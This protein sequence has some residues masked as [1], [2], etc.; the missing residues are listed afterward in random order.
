MPAKRISG[1]LLTGL[2]FFAGAAHA[3][4]IGNRVWNDANGN[5]IQEAGEAGLNGVKVLLY[6]D[7]NCN[8]VIDGADALQTTATTAAGTCSVDIPPAADNGCYS[9]T[10]LAKACFQVYVDDDPL[11]NAYDGSRDYSSTT[12]YTNAG[13]TTRFTPIHLRLASATSAY[14]RADFGFK[15]SLLTLEENTSQAL[16]VDSNGY[17]SGDG[18][19][20]FHVGNRVCNNS[21][22]T[23]D[24]VIVSLGDGVSPGTFPNTTCN[25]T[26]CTTDGG[27]VY[28]SGIAA[29]VYS[30]VS[31]DPTTPPAPND[32]TRY[33]GS[34][35]AHSCVGVYWAVSYQLVDDCTKDENIAS[36][37]YGQVTC[38]GTDPSFAN[39]SDPSPSDPP[40]YVSDDLRYEFSVWARQWDGVT[41]TNNV[42]LD[43]FIIVRSEISA[44]A[45]K[46]QP[47]GQ[48]PSRILVDGVEYDG[49]SPVG[50]TP[51]QIVAVTVENATIGTVGAGFDSNSDGKFDYDG[52]FQPV[53][54]LAYYNTDVMRLID[55]QGVINGKCGGDTFTQTLDNNSFF[56]DMDRFNLDGSSCGGTA[57]YTYTFVIFGA[58]TSYIS[59]YQEVASGANNEKYNG[60]YCGDDPTAFPALC[61][62]FNSA[63]NQPEIEKTVDILSYDGASDQVLT[64]TLQYRNVSPTVDI[65]DPENNAIVIYDEIPEYPTYGQFVANSADPG[66]HLDTAVGGGSHDYV[67][68]NGCRVEYSVDTYAV[69][70]ARK[71]WTS[72]EPAAADVRALRFVLLDQIP[73]DGWGEVSFQI[74]V[75]STFTGV[76]Q[77]IADIRV[78]SGT[79]LDQ[80]D[81]NT[82]FRVLDEC[83]FTTAA[84]ISGFGAG[85]DVLSRPYLWWSTGYEV[86]TLGF[87]LERR[88]PA[89]G[90]Y[91]R[92]TPELVRADAG[93]QGAS[94]YRV[95][96]TGAYPGRRYSYRLVEQ[97]AGGGQP[98]YGPFEVT[99]P[100]RGQ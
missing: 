36:P 49:T 98:H 64:Y 37:T 47:N 60:D 25:G 26:T 45:N 81:A 97:E 20:M 8:G 71:A 29:G 38:T 57:T 76:Y 99:I 92:V 91:Q 61:I 13:L 96:D 87:W 54:D 80:D 1:L 62:E 50:V 73:A 85:T 21:D 95:F 22:S 86:N 31:I 14:V 84:M 7:A 9:F 33:V 43:D 89:T 48:P 90:K 74:N 67:A 77:N 55:I 16:V 88:D 100:E 59:P 10:G 17:A 66:C 70:D 83:L 30:L 44:S 12:G 93:R 11:N 40:G 46:I 24:D 68:T 42:Q 69:G 78:D 72:V 39:G 63:A 34:I 41:E 18:P 2:F 35:P 75:D 19:D 3:A 58:G 32:T 27:V 28:N 4:S 23:V 65:G 51:G 82:C 15:D 6:T 53:G 56:I 94:L 5:G 52:W 79:V